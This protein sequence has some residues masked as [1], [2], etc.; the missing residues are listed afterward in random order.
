MAEADREVKAL[1]ESRADAYRPDQGCEAAEALHGQKLH[2]AHTLVVARAAQGTGGEERGE[3]GADEATHAVH[4]EDVQG[5][6]RQA[7]LLDQRRHAIADRACDEADADGAGHAHE[8]ASRGDGAEAR[9]HAGHRRLHRRLG[10]V[11]LDDQP[12][13]RAHHGGGRSH[14]GCHGRS[15]A[16]VQG[17]AAIE[18]KPAH[19][20]E[21]G[22]CQHHRHVVGRRALVREARPRGQH[23]RRHDGS[24]TSGRV[25]DEATREVADALLRE[26]APAPDPMAD[27]AVDQDLPES[28]KD[29]HRYEL[30][31]FCP[32]AD[33][34]GRRDDRECALK[35]E[36]HDQWN[37]VFHSVPVGPHWLEEGEIQVANVGLHAAEA[38][39]VANGSPEQPADAHDAEALHE[40]R[41]HVLRLHEATVE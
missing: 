14:G 11:A 21:A 36:K 16:A 33:D 32:R 25:H 18:A 23:Q 7:P 20:Q 26:P 24:T 6:V 1:D 38:Q 8:A 9:D 15:G 41:E 19:P 4:A 30:G 39:G 22:A 34:Q 37:V 17:T 35:E 27:R 29:Q 2:H 31:A 40:D 28:A 10:T 13:E 5:V 3:H 12:H